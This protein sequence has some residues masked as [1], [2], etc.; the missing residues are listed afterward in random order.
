MGIIEILFALGAVL[1]TW[2]LGLLVHEKKV[3]GLK[4]E[5][6]KLKQ[7]SFDSDLAAIRNRHLN[8]P[9]ESLLDEDEYIDDQEQD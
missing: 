5:I 8:T 9:L 2:G 4:Y 3:G 7:K 1:V 6:R